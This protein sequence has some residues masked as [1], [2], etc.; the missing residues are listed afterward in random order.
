MK[1][2]GL[3]TCCCINFQMCSLENFIICPS[4]EHDQF[5]ELSMVVLKLD[6]RDFEAGYK[7]D[8]AS[9]PLKKTEEAPPAKET[10]KGKRKAREFEVPQ[11]EGS[12][13]PITIGSDDEEPDQVQD[14]EA[15]GSQVPITPQTGHG[16]CSLLPQRHDHGFS[17]SSLPDH[18]PPSK[19]KQMET[20]SVESMWAKVLQMQ[21]LAQAQH[22]KEV[23]DMFA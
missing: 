2:I 10:D 19:K 8:E 23:A 16:S 17:D 4:D 6:R 20:D 11:G 7:V 1:L 14:C 13:R 12:A 15:W 5:L 3:L 21:A 9:H 18:S 22:K